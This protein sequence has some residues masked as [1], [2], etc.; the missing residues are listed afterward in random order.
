MNFKREKVQ[1][2]YLRDTHVENVFINEYMVGAPGD[3]VK[4]F[5]LAS[6]YVELELPVSNES[7]ARELK[8]SLE[9]V[10][11]AWT[12]WE[13]CGVIRKHYPDPKD[14][15]RYEVE[16]LN[17]REAL[18]GGGRKKSKKEPLPEKVKDLVDDK[19]LRAL[20]SEIEG[21]TG[22]LLAGKESLEIISWMDDFGATPEVIAYAYRHC[23]ALRKTDKYTYVASVVKDWAGRGLKTRAQVEEFLEETDS[24]NYL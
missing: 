4:V 16:F 19:G 2:Y 3:Y 17:L 23:V 9:E 18:A 21:I 8:L 22:R 7:L 6:M 14:K 24:R 10:L 12:Y 20:Y 13:D 1:N 15:L 11:L 5:L